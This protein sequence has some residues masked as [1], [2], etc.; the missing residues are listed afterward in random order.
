MDYLSCSRP[1]NCRDPCAG[2]TI[3]QGPRIRSRP[4][5]CFVPLFDSILKVRFVSRFG[6]LWRRC[7]CSVSPG[8]QTE[9]CFARARVANTSH[10]MP[11]PRRQIGVHL[12]LRWRRGAAWRHQRCQQIRKHCHRS[13]MMMQLKN[14]C[15]V[16]SG[17]FFRS[18]SQDM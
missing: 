5:I 4:S 7:R 16:Q 15:W 10:T 1:G 18:P 12:H 2:L 17:S 13:A 3:N 9:S 6:W 11:R 14:N 8:S